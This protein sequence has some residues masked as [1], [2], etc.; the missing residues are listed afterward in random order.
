MKKPYI[1]ILF[2]VTWLIVH[3]FMIYKVKQK[4][5]IQIGLLHSFTG[6]LKESET[7]LYLAA[8]LAVDEINKNGGVLGQKVN[9]LVAD[10]MSKP[11]VFAENA[12]RLLNGQALEEFDIVKGEIVADGGAH[13][14]VSAIFG[15]WSSSSRK[16]VIPIIEQFNSLLFYSVQYEGAEGPRDSSDGNV[17]YL[18]AAANQQLLPSISWARLH[19]GQTAYLIGSNYIYPRVTYELVKSCFKNECGGNLIGARF[20][21]LSKDDVI[22]FKYAVEDIKRNKPDYI[23]NTLNGIKNNKAFFKALAAANLKKIPIVLSYSITENDIRNIYSEMPKGT[24]IVNYLCWNYFADLGN[25]QNQSFYN[26]IKNV[27]S[28]LSTNDSLPPRIR[29]QVNKFLANDRLIITEPMVDTYA[30]IKL[31]AIACEKAGTINPEVVRKEILGS[32]FN[33]PGGITYIDEKNGHS[34]KTLRIGKLEKDRLDIVWSSI[35]PIQPKP[36]YGDPDWTKVLKN[37]KTQFG[38]NW[39]SQSDADTIIR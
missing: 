11:Q 23:I 1:I 16:R 15:T 24:Q 7:P 21:N 22:D 3:S 25:Q 2:L 36:Y 14:K 30:A 6:T 13:A 32:T 26:K 28:K 34:W 8:K 17:V 19:L 12:K 37:L 4:K 29:Q 33:G 27:A 39:E 10:G 18:G 5:D 38:G 35:G 9:M 31:W 20:V